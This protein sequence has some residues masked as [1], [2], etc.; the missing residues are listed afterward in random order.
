MVLPFNN[1]TAALPHGIT[2]APLE[3][4]TFPLLGG[5]HS[6][7]KRK[8]LPLSVGT[9]KSINSKSALKT[10]SCLRNGLMARGLLIM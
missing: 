5:T 8:L 1:L 3:G 9:M 10:I 6:G 7:K 4:T 2:A